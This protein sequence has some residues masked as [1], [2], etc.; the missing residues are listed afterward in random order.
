MLDA[1]PDGSITTSGAAPL[2]ARSTGGRYTRALEARPCAHA[3]PRTSSTTTAYGGSR[4]DDAGNRRRVT[5]LRK[6]TRRSG[7][8]SYLEAGGRALKMERYTRRRV[9]EIT[10]IAPTSLRTRRERP[11]CVPR[12]TRTN[13]RQLRAK[14]LVRTKRR[15]SISP[16]FTRAAKLFYDAKATF[17]ARL[18]RKTSPATTTTPRGGY[19]VIDAS[20]RPDCLIWIVHSLRLSPSAEHG[21]PSSTSLDKRSTLHHHRGM[22]CSAR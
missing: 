7:P 14:V 10:R 4:R 21:S 11:S 1:K 20:P 19:M 12:T 22:R 13:S 8:R 15:V 16:G 5:D 3:L 18:L 2:P 9:Q 6:S 17:I